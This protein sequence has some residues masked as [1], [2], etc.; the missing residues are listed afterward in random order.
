MAD[1]LIGKANAR[2]QMIG[3][4][5]YAGHFLIEAEKKGYV[6]PINFKSKWISYQQKEAKQWRF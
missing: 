4:L 1:F 5:L 3:E 2:L 6:L